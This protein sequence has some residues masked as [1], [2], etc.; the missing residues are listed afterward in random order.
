MAQVRELIGVY[1]PTTELHVKDIV[2]RLDTVYSFSI[3][4]ADENSS[5]AT[6]YGIKY[7]PTFLLIKNGAILSKKVGKYN[8]NIYEEWITNYGWDS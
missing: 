5:T 1:N 2:G 4:S 6:R 3:N 8:I 7:F